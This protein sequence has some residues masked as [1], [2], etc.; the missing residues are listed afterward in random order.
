V[1]TFRT[2]RCWWSATW[3]ALRYTSFTNTAK[4]VYAF[5]L[6]QL[7]PREPTQS[8]QLGD[9]PGGRSAAH[10]ANQP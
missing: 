8:C 2:H 10:D 3:T 7:L 1:R 5:T 9:V 6:V 4:R